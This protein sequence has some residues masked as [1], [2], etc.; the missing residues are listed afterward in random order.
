M[1]GPVLFG[2]GLASN[3]LVQQREGRKTYAQKKK[4]GTQ[5]QVQ[6]RL[7]EG[8]AA[9]PRRRNSAAAKQRVRR[10]SPRPEP[11]LPF[12]PESIAGRD[13]T[14]HRQPSSDA[15]ARTAVAQAPPPP[16]TYSE[17]RAVE[18]R[19]PLLEGR[20]TANFRDPDRTPS[21]S[22]WCHHQ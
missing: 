5:T 1:F 20:A 22:T 17:R 18:N 16:L 14:Y 13:F 3:D 7:C 10:P 6:C 19:N 11:P 8:R 15:A 21:K 2:P 12:A 4:N 9:P